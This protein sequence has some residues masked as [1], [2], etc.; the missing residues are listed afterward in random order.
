MRNNKFFNQESSLLNM[1]SLCYL[2]NSPTQY[3]CG[4]FCN[5]EVVC[6]SQKPQQIDRQHYKKKRREIDD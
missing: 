5:L 1:Y 3:A 4:F 6:I 2:P